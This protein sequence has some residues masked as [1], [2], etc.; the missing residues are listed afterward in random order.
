ME[1]HILIPMMKKQGYDEDFAADVTLTSSMQGLLIPPSHNMIIYAMAAGGTASIAALFMAGI[2]PGLVLAAVLMVYSYY[3]SV[4][5]HYPKGE[6]FSIKRLVKTFLT[7]FCGLMTLIIIIV[8]CT[9][10]IC[11]ATEAAAISILWALIVTTF[12][13]KDMTLAKLWNILGRSLHT[14]AVVMIC[15]A[16]SAIFGFLIA[17]LKVPNLLT[18]AILGVTTNKFIVLLLINIILIM[19]GMIMD[20]GSILIIAT[21]IFL[22]L[23]QSVGIHPVHFG[24]IMI[25][26]LAIGLMT[27]PVGGALMVGSVVAK[28][29]YEELVKSLVPWLIIMFI[30]LLAITYIPGFSMFLPGVL[31]LV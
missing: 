24:I 30:T 18:N 2:V 9:T 29:K 28:M 17:Y 19:L 10:G 7:S 1:V 3:L 21:P 26:N 27:P 14:I 5:N 23:A 4:K 6:R 13:Y 22:P 15:M 8:G 12:I 25:F 16:F 31:G 20:M 11:T